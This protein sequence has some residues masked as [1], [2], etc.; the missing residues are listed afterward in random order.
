MNCT[1]RKAVTGDYEA[2]NGIMTQ[3]QQI[4]IDLRPDIYKKLAPVIAFDAFEKT[5]SDGTLYVAEQGG[6]VVG[7]TQIVFRHIES[8]THVTRDVIYIETM[9][10]DEN[11]RGQGIGHKLFEKVKEIKK[12]KGL[13]G[14]EL[15]VNAK[16][17]AAYEMYKNYGFTEKSV[18][19]ELLCD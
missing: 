19:M 16:N 13:D 7:I 4:H 5:V 6:K 17:V 18:N 9:A 15:Q 12:Q 14:I 1:V 2:V 8:P 11:Y 3:V 10:V